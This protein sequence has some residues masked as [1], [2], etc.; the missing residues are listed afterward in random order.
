VLINILQGTV[1]IS[2]L[3]AMVRIAAPILLAALGELVTERAGVLNLGMEGIML[4]GA[5]TGFLVAHRTGSIPLALLAAIG[6]G[7]VVGLLMVFMASTLKVD[8]VVTGLALN[9]LA[10]GL[11]FYWYRVAFSSVGTTPTIEIMK[12]IKIPLLS[13]IPVLGEVVFSQHPLTYFALLMVPLTWFFINK[14][15][16]GLELRCLGEEPRAIDIKGINVTQRQYL[17]VIFGGMMAGLG[18]AFLTV[19]SAGLFL[20][21][22]SAG[23]GWLAIVVVI[24]GNWQPFRILLAV[25]AFS[26]FDAF[27]LQAQ[28]LGVVFP[29]QILLAL[30]YILAI[31]LLISSR[32]KSEA[33]AHLGVAYKRE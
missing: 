12:I 24:A 2:M 16:Y 26:F 18:G 28:S 30:P 8:Q 6:A 23:R 29:Y 19:S 14:T 9:L 1:I 3:S 33:P 25:L 17:A 21:N 32:S 5:F 31:V 13:S 22:M 27:Q 7:G 15:R 10:A 20:P 4:T 11:T